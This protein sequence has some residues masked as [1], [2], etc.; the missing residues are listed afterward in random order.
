M[1]KAAES[2]EKDKKKCPKK[3]LPIEQRQHAKK[4][5]QNKVPITECRHLQDAL[6][7]LMFGKTKR[8]YPTAKQ[9]Q[10]DDVHAL[11]ATRAPKVPTPQIRPRNE[12]DSAVTDPT[13]PN[14]NRVLILTSFLGR[15][16]TF[17]HSHT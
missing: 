5:E 13:D 3:S 2:D 14:V 7:P 11:K 10:R 9:S 4:S 8:G 6:V 15:S 17:Q 12:G 1:D 16:T